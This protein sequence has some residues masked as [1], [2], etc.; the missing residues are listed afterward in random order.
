[1]GLPETRQAVPCCDPT[2]TESQR[3]QLLTIFG[4]LV[5]T[6]GVVAARDAARSG[7]LTLGG[8]P[9]R[10]TGLRSGRARRSRRL[11][12]SGLRTAGGLVG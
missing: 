10:R 11:A 3:W 9:A 7:G 6:F 2:E 5:V 8:S 4:V 12:L 1:M